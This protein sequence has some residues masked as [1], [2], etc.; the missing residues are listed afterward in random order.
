MKEILILPRLAELVIHE[1]MHLPIGG[2]EVVCPYYINKFKERAG[3]RV[4]VGKGDPGEIV[5]EVK[6]WAKLKDFD[7]DKASAEQIR[8]FMISRG[9]GIDCSG[10]VV[11]VIGFWVKSTRKKHLQYYLKFPK[12]DILNL[13]RRLL[14]P[15]ENMGADILTSELN[16]R[17]V[18]NLNNVRPGDFVRSKGKVKNSHHIML[19][20]RVTKID[21]VVKEIEYVHSSRYYDDNNGIRFGVIK[22]TD[23]L[24]P[25]ELQKWL[26]VEDGKNYTYDTFMNQVEDNGIRRLKNVKIAH[27]VIVN[28]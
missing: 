21:G 12:N 4:L 23:P 22:V 24:K 2:K 8:E 1:Y 19:V 13:L 9:I 25:L 10:F 14:R 3:L 7:M 16:C 5:K 6:V 27:E 17:K 28:N 26:E 20:R 11:H 18:N 15:V